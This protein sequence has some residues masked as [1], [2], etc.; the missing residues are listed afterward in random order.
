MKECGAAAAAALRQETFSLS[1]TK[2][3]RIGCN[4][5]RI[6]TSNLTWRP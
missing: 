1:Q 3:I 4:Q 5:Y 2:N 6:T